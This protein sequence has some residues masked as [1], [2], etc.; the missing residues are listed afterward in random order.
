MTSTY[1]QMKHNDFEAKMRQQVV[2]LGQLAA[3]YATEKMN[4]SEWE[5]R[6]RYILRRIVELTVDQF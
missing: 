2:K 3:D 1:A 4:R 5:F 6:R